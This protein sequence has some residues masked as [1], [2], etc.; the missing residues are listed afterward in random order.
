MYK[1]ALYRPIR[2]RRQYT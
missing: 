2:Y 1:I